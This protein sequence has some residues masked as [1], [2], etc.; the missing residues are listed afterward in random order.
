MEEQKQQCDLNTLRGEAVGVAATV[1]LEQSVPLE[2]SQIVAELV[3]TVGGI[4]EGEG[5]QRGL[6]DFPGGPAA[7]VG[8]AVHENFEEAD[9]PGVVNLDAGI[10]DRAEGRWQSHAL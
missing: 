4:G 9:H 2:F 8:A 3:E 6:V 10:A 7:N 1:A 5:G